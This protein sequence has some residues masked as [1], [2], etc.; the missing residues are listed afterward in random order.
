MTTFGR[1]RF[2]Q[3]ASYNIRVMRVTMDGGKSAKRKPRRISGRYWRLVMANLV[4]HGRFPARH[5]QQLEM[6]KARVLDALIS[7][8]TRRGL[9][10]WCV[11]WQ[12]HG[13]TGYAH[14]DVLL[15]YSQRVRNTPGWYDYLGKHC[16]MTRYR[17]VN[18]AILEYG[19]KEDPRPLRAGIE[20]SGVLLEEQFRRE[21]YRVMRD[22]MMRDPVRFNALTWLKD[23]NI[24][25][26]AS[27]LSWPKHIRFLRMCQEQEC[28]RRIARVPSFPEITRELIES[29]L[30]ADELRLYDSWP[31]YGTIVRYLNQVPRWGAHRPHKTKNLYLWGPPDTGKTTLLNALRAATSAYPFGVNRW[32][33]RFKTGTYRVITWNEFRLGVMAYNNLLQLLEGAP[34]DLEYK[35]GSSLKTCNPL[36]VMTS[37]LPPCTHLGIKFSWHAQMHA[38]SLANFE[39]RV[40]SVRVN[41]SRPLFI[42]LKLLPSG[43]PDSGSDV[44][45]PGDVEVPL[46]RDSE[47]PSVGG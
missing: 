45:S 7:R 36:V 18:R 33:P 26:V 29:R 44:T 23:N 20:V 47:R 10:G 34:M 13:G 6:R 22:E 27:G 2:G 40:E 15:V 3:M 28:N 42:L 24:D 39:A 41:A 16:S 38:A 35:G 19:R 43:V 37:N 30:S 25:V 14:L 21:P 32:W 11:A 31:G 17:T 4:E 8:E 12:T 1:F 46:A 9:T 5:S